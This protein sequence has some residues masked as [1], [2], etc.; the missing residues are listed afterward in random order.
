MACA[1]ANK[2]L[3]IVSDAHFL[4]EVERKRELMVRG[5]MALTDTYGVFA[6]VRGDGL[7]LGCELQG[8]WQDRARDILTA[9]LDSGLMVLVAGTNVIRLAPALNIPDENIE[10]GLAR[11]ERA[12]V[13]L[14]QGG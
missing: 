7:L 3:E 2:V 12:L 11:M 9:C 5:L 13:S 14:V 10:E 8:E 6:E 1:V 4:V